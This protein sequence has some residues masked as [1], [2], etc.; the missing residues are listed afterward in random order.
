M[1]N[2]HSYRDVS[3]FTIAIFI[4]SHIEPKSNNTDVNS[5]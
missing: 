3:H 1:M 4:P 5:N 2:N